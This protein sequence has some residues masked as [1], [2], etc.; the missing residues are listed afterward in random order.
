MFATSCGAPASCA[1]SGAAETIR[2][3]T[4]ILVV[5][6]ADMKTSCV[7]VFTS[8]ARSLL[9]LRDL[10]HTKCDFP[11]DRVFPAARPPDPLIDLALNGSTITPDSNE[12]CGRD[13]PRVRP[14]P[15]AQ[16]PRKRSGKRTA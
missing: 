2:E 5:Y 8:L 9:A 15:K 14:A 16:P 13:R 10:R 11:C 3:T 1:R 12:P 7:S 6:L 4:R